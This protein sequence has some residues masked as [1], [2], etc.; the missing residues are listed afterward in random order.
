MPGPPCRHPYDWPAPTGDQ[1]ADGME[2][3][4]PE[5]LEV[6]TSAAQNKGPN[7]GLRCSTHWKSRVRV[8]A[9]QPEV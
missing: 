8:S 2:A 3:A 9:G 4:D 1:R 6:T 5:D 7:A